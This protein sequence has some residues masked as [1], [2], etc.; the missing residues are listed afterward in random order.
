MSF[1]YERWKQS[2]YSAMEQENSAAAPFPTA[3]TWAGMIWTA[4]G[5]LA[6]LSVAILSM[7]T[8]TVRTP[9]SILG[10]LFFLYGGVRATSGT[11]PGTFRSG[12]GSI[13]LGFVSIAQGYMLPSLGRDSDVVVQLVCWG[14]GG[15]FLFAGFL[16]ATADASYQ[17]WR[18]ARATGS[19]RPPG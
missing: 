12:I 2:Q 13:L 19:S 11:T 10:G 9:G 4:I 15:A 3:V 6:L 8:G 16:A 7:Q 18:N 17:K 14:F 1:D 5:V